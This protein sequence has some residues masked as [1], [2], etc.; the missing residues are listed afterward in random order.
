MSASKSRSRI[1]YLFCTLLRLNSFLNSV[2]LDWFPGWPEYGY[3]VKQPSDD[4][5][6]NED[7]VELR[8]NFRLPLKG[9]KQTTD[10]Y[11]NDR[12]CDAKN[13]Y[14][15]QM[16][17]HQGKKTRQDWRLYLRALLCWITCLS[18]KRICL[19][20]NL[21]DD[22]Y[23]W[24]CVCLTSSFT[25]N[26]SVWQMFPPTTHVEIIGQFVNL[27]SLTTSLIN[28]SPISQSVLSDNPSFWQPVRL[29]TNISHN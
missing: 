12:N 26:S 5:Y 25:D 13:G 2:R 17:K 15:C 3:D 14:I 18:R 10:F 16:Y 11:W 6:A 24:P 8:R 7:C 20:T 27:I 22:L 4:G 21:F 29:K 19:A 28:N 9:G 23:A 1:P